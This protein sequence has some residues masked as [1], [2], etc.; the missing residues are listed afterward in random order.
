MSR[1]LI[2]APIND[3]MCPMGTIKGVMPKH[4]DNTPTAAELYDQAVKDF[5][6]DCMRSQLIGKK[7]I[8]PPIKKQGEVKKG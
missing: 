3:R 4:S 8:Q 5:T 6:D 1:S 7:D 2:G